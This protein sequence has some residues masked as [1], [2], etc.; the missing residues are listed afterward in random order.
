MAATEALRPSVVRIQTPDWGGTGFVYKTSGTTAYIVTAS[1]LLGSHHL[2]E[3][4]THDRIMVEGQIL[5]AD[6]HS[7]I[8]VVKACCARFEAG[9]FGSS[10]T[11]RVGQEIMS[12]GYALNLQGA[13]TL[14]TGIVSWMGPEN[15]VDWIQTDAPIN[16]GNSGGPLFYRDGKVMGI[17]TS[18]FE[19]AV[20]IGLAVSE[21]TIRELLPHLEAAPPRP[22]ATPTPTPKPNLYG[23]WLT[24][25]VLQERYGYTSDPYIHLYGSGPYPTIIDYDIQV[26]CREGDNF[27]DV[28]VRELAL[29]D[30]LVEEDTSYDLPVAVTLDGRN[31]GSEMWEAYHDVEEQK[32]VY[33]APE[34]LG[35]RIAQAL[36]EGASNLIV[37]VAPGADYEST[38][39]FRVAGGAEAIKPVLRA[40]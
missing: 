15:G 10:R 17:V 20:G 11:L 21:T 23:E 39:Q 34:R 6:D 25:P 13:A 14:N 2:V 7:D 5:G 35:W 22:K 28:V 12:L 1:H 4:T 3:V 19:D 26:V 8:A 30:D 36:S 29:V 38:I 32:V 18:R 9:V 40:C 31:W 37:I 33:Y 27:V 24:W 16:P